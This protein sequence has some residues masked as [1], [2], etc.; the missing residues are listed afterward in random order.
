MRK[1]N[2]NSRRG[3][4]RGLQ[5][6]RRNFH[7]TTENNDASSNKV[8]EKQN[9][10]RSL[11]LFLQKLSRKCFL[12][13]IALNTK[14][15]LIPLSHNI[16][17]G[18]F[19]IVPRWRRVMSY[20]LYSAFALV[21]FHKFCECIQL[22]QRSNLDLRMFI[23]LDGFLLQLVPVCTALAHIF[24]LE[25]VTGV[26][27]CFPKVLSNLGSECGGG[28]EFSPF[29]D[30]GVALRV[31]FIIG[32]AIVSAPT[33]PMLSV[34]FDSVPI[35]MFPALNRVGLITTGPE[36]MFSTFVWQLV[37]YPLEVIIYG[38]PLLLLTFTGSIAIV[39]L[40]VFKVYVSQLR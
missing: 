19:T 2:G 40:G 35:F 25:E 37:L 9:Y 1:T 24:S 4:A 6:F 27:N 34:Y 31:M 10:G 18:E 21:I 38:I 32:G 20:V 17:T 13:S 36:Q 33:F 22:A 7:P 12:R 29:D 30:L 3:P 11:G 28:V 8:F 5:K 23:S 39:Q 15:N 16:H 26:M 14:L